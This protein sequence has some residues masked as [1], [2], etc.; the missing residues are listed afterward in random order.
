[1]K[2]QKGHTMSAEVRAKIS[3]KMKGVKKSP[4]TVARMRLAQRGV[5]K[6]IQQIEKHRIAITGKKASAVTRLKMSLKR[7]KEKH[8]MWKGG[9]TPI[10]SQIRNCFKMRQWVSDIFHRDNFTCQKCFIRGGKL[11]AHHLK[12]FSKIFKENNIKSLE[13]ALNCEEFWD[14]NNG[15]TICVDCH[16][17]INTR[18]DG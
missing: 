5:V 2:F 13:D 15:Q 10:V 11:N 17:K 7:R 12:P 3:K 6:T 16:R 1:M 14:L 4:E 8:P 9:I 18:R